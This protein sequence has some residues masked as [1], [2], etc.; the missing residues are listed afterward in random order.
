MNTPEEIRKKIGL[1]ITQKNLNYR[2]ISKML[3]RADSYIQQYITRGYPQVLKEKDRKK[4]SEILEVPEQELTNI[5]ITPKFSPTTI[6]Y[7]VGYVQAGKFN[8]AC[9]LP[10]SEWETIPY[11]INDNYKKA[12]VFALGVRGDSMNLV[13]PPEKTTLICCPLADWLEANP[14]TDIEGKYIIAYRRTP[15]GLCEATVKKYTKIDDS[16]IILVAES[17]NPEIKPIVLHP[18]SNEYE[19]Y[20]VV[21]GDMRFY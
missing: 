17:T 9:Q 11:P 16:T 2:S 20:A 7:K 12:N 13:F 10:E 14:E 6:I 19:I 8:E 4:L 18:D 15:D 5:D 1:L 3:G 21:I